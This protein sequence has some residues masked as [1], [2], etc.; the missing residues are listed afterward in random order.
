MGRP[1]KKKS[2]RIFYLSE[3]MDRLRVKP[4]DLARGIK[5]T[6]TYVSE[7][8]SRRKG[9]PSPD[10]LL[11]ISEFLGLSVNDL[12]TKPP[13]RGTIEA[14]QA[15]NPREIAALGR[16]IERIDRRGGK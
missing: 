9:Q 12:F 7:M 6:E 13:D 10:V 16:L 2:E 4:V 14:A 5:V 1:R 11:D 15:L 8:R 3:W